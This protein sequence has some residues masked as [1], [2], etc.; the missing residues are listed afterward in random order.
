M[1]GPL[2]NN[3]IQRR[4]EFGLGEGYILER[5]ILDIYD[6]HA[7]WP[8]TTARS[9]HVLIMKTWY[10]RG[11]PNYTPRPSTGRKSC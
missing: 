10:H 6:Y 7:T 3:V 2:H 9:D 8:L 5:Y 1:T 11:Q 4:N